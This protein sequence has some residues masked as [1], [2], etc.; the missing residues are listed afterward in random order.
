[1]KIVHELVNNMVLDTTL[2]IVFRVAIQHFRQRVED[3][4]VPSEAARASQQL[5]KIGRLQQAR[6]DKK[7]PFAT[8]T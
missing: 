4:E 1:M 6:A 8:K 3:A 7:Y 2:D 5:D